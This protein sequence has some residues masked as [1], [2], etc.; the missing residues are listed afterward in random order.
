MWKSKQTDQT[1]GETRREM[2]RMASRLSYVSLGFAAWMAASILE[3]D[4]GTEW[5]ALLIGWAPALELKAIFFILLYVTIRTALRY[6]EIT[7]A[8]NA[9]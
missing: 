4:N 6:Y 8:E 7:D 5:S 2:L 1:K 3:R 9:S